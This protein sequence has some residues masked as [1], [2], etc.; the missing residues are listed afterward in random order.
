M[1]GN[2]TKA[3]YKGNVTNFK[4]KEY[5]QI[6][7]FSKLLK[8]R[9]GYEI[10]ITAQEPKEWNIKDKKLIPD[11]FLIING[12]PY[13]IEVKHYGGLYE[14]PIKIEQVEGYE[15]NHKD[16]LVL[17]V[18]GHYKP[19]TEEFT[20]FNLKDIDRTKLSS[21]VFDGNK[22]CYNIPSTNEWFKFDIKENN[23]DKKINK[24][25]NKMIKELSTYNEK[26]L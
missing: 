9:L 8:N 23:T 10:E 16:T 20:L 24:L 1:I 21:I 7:R 22:Y 17:Y 2:R 25:Q 18:R 12:K 13:H 19:E 11:Y 14:L 6:V 26:C 3:E 5:E 4:S 15:R